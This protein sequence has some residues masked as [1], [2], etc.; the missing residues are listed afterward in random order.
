M[1]KPFISHCERG[2]TYVKAL[3]SCYGKS[4]SRNLRIFCSSYPGL[5]VK[6]NEDFMKRISAELS[7]TYFMSFTLSVADKKSVNPIKL[8]ALKCLN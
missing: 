7:F 3:V 5:D 2:G 8:P 4:G 6:V 1:K